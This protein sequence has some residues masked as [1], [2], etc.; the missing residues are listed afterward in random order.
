MICQPW[1]DKNGGRDHGGD[2]RD[3]YQRLFLNLRDGLKDGD[4]QSHNQPNDEQRRGDNKSNEKSLANKIA[5]LV[6]AHV[7]P[8]PA[9]GRQVAAVV[10]SS[11]M[12]AQVR[13]AA[14]SQNYPSNL[15]LSSAIHPPEQ[16]AKV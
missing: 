9:C 2:L 7:T 11:L 3:E 13:V 14:T 16:T 6:N 1:S 10:A 8:F 5:G 4:D 15:P 12:R